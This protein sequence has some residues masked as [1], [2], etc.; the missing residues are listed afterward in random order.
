MKEWHIRHKI[1]H[2]IFQNQDI[3]DDLSK[4]TIIEEWSKDCIIK[5]ALEYPI[6]QTSELY[7]PGKSYAVAIT[8]AFLIEKY[9]NSPFLENLD[10]EKLLFENDPYFVRYSEDQ[11]TYNTI[12]KKFP[13]EKIQSKTNPGVENFQKTQ[14]YFLKEFLLHEET[15]IYYSP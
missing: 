3:G 4:E 7:Y 8:F 15:K 2:N 14:T 13:F 11:E 1:F 10:D 9:F 6:T 5:R 12:I